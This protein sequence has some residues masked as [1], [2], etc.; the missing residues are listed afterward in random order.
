M[1]KVYR[2]GYINSNSESTVSRYVSIFET[3]V[4]K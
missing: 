3:L 4:T 1:K 2:I